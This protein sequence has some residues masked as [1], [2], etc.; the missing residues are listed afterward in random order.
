MAKH[1]KRQADRSERPSPRPELER[2]DPWRVR[3][4][5]RQCPGMRVD[6]LLYATPELMQ[7]GIEDGAL[8]QIA[9]VAHLPG[10][11]GASLGMPDLHFG[12]GFPI[13]GVAAFDAAE[14]VVSPGGVGYDINCGVRLARSELRLD[15]VRGRI[16]ALLGECYRSVPAGVGGGG[17]VPLTERTLGEV[18]KLGSEWAVRSGYGEEADLATTE[19]GGRLPGA[20]PGV[21]SERARA[22]ALEQLGT[23]GSGNHFLEIQVVEEVVDAETARLFGIGE[24]GRLAVMIHCGSR[25]FGHQVCDDAIALMQGATRKYGIHVPDR[26]LG[27]APVRSPEGE[28]YLA[29]MACAANYAWANRQIILHRVRGAFAR[30]LG[31]QAGQLELVYDVAHNIAKLERHATEEGERELC[32]HRKGATRAFA[33][34]RPEVPEVYREV[35]QPVIVPGDMGRAS[36]VLVGAEGA[37]RET[38]GSTCHGAGRLM[39]RS[40]AAAL[41]SGRQVVEE[42]AAQGTL[43]MGHSG[44]GIAEEQPAAY[45]DVSEVVRAACG[46]GLARRVARLRPLAVIKG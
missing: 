41:K 24:P 26:Q 6:G 42:L 25:G 34:G 3:L 18:C 32:V 46:A 39:S 17:G 40:R 28:R 11:V 38:F 13:G 22:R 37:M 16:E 20:D 10:I 14:G 12:Y 29:A 8:Q 45:K 4:D 36:W 23:L 43:V 19:D 2:I 44:T 35:G 31:A 21:L 9:N 15:D 30:V 1:Q 7:D 33:P 27:C 5:R